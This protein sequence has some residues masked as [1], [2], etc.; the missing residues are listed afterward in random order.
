MASKHNAFENQSGN[1]PSGLVHDDKDLKAQAS[2]DQPVSTHDRMGTGSS[3][4]AELGKISGN[5]MPSDKTFLGTGKGT[6]KSPGDVSN[7][8]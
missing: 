7:R 8:T 1:P 2:R 3:K 6:G 4:T 5:S